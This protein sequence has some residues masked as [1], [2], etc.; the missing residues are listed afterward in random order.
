MIKDESSDEDVPLLQQTQESDSDAPMASQCE[1]ADSDE[2]LQ[3]EDSGSEDESKGTKRKRA[4]QNQSKAAIE[5][6]GE[7]RWTTLIHKGPRFPEPY[8]PLP[9][10][11]TLKYE[12]KRVL[13]P[14][15]AEEVAMFYAVK[16]ETQHA[17]NATFNQN[18]FE[19]FQSFLKKHPPVRLPSDPARWN[20]DQEVRRT[21]FP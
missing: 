6:G 18:F 10:S 4:T 1:E 15:E 5:G 7:Q 21:R 20:Q 2:P 17:Q 19:D 9:E 8:Q 3:N 13:L 16:L 11:V 14:P 12:G